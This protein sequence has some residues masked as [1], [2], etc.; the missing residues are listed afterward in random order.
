[1]KNKIVKGIT[2]VLLLSFV[3]ACTPKKE[4]TAAQPAALDKEKI[5]SAI[6]ALEQSYADALNSGKIEGL[7]YYA[8]D[9]NSYPQDKPPLVG[10]AAIDVKL[11]EEVKMN[12]GFKASFSVDEV[13]PSNDGELVVEIGS[14]KISDSTNT[15]KHSGNYI[16]VFHKKDGKYVCVRDMSASDKE[17][18]ENKK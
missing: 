2:L 3:I 14:Y 11:L 7:A 1:M 8:D 15:V 16:S 5:K 18:E 6:Q 12:K 4:E 9:A 13:H 10:K 17:K